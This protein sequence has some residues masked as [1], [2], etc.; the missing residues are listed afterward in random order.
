MMVQRA[1]ASYRA[2]RIRIPA[3]QQ[4]QASYLGCGGGEGGDGG[5]GGGLQE[6]EQEKHACH[7]TGNSAGC[8]RMLSAAL[9]AQ[10][11]G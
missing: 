11:A 9:S 2:A 5:L 10:L 3:D 8:L 1:L 7:L 4:A 6:V